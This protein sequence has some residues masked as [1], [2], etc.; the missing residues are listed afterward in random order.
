M[1]GKFENKLIV[2]AV[3][4][5][6]TE[7]GSKGYFANTFFEL[8]ELIKANGPLSNFEH[9]DE[10]QM[11][12]YKKDCPIGFNL[13]CEVVA[14]PKGVTDEQFVTFI[15]DYTFLDKT[16]AEE[17]LDIIK[18]NVEP[19]FFETAQSASEIKNYIDGKFEYE[20][21]VG[22]DAASDYEIPDDL[23]D[24]IEWTQ[25]GEYVLRN[26]DRYVTL[27]SGTFVKVNF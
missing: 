26:D 19:Q 9:Y 16:D 13:Y 10:D 20:E 1:N 24:F 12:F 4:Y 25:Y 21:D 17:L 3:N 18:R 22:R 8:Y 14:A 23:D 7:A 2:T 15:M 27:D 5:D 6:Y 11:L